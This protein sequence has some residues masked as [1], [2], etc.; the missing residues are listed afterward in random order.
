V[1]GD[2]DSMR[3]VAGL[4]NPGRRYERTRHN[5]GF[6]VLRALRR[7][8]SWPA[9]RSAFGGRTWSARPG[10]TD[11]QRRVLLLA[12]QTYMNRSGEAVGEMMRFHKASAADLLVVVDDLALPPGQI[13]LRAGG[14]AGG[15]KG[16]ADVI[17]ALGTEQFARLRIGI[18]PAPP[19]M[20]A[21]DF[22]LARLSADEE[23]EL[24]AAVQAAADAVEDW[25]FHDI[26]RVMDKVNRKV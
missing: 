21:A 20:E 13:R 22:V 24:T 26:E 1:Q 14:S 18:G 2:Q 4:G 7:R 15:H 25:V 23:A 17:R 12:P 16:L 6:E 9:E 3:L 5:L 8:W 19:G 10:P 11:R